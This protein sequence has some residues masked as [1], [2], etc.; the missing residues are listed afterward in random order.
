MSKAGVSGNM[1]LREFKSGCESWGVERIGKR[2]VAVGGVQV[3]TSRV[4]PLEGGDRERHHR[5]L[6]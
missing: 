6:Q 3:D 2:D 1:V 4:S 5:R